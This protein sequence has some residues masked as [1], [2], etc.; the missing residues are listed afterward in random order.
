MLNKVLSTI[1]R[2]LLQVIE[3]ALAMRLAA[4]GR[5]FDVWFRR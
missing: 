4:A 1:A 3:N 2:L 5:G